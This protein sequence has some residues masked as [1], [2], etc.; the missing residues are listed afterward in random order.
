MK[1]NFPSAQL[2]EMDHVD[3]HSKLVSV[4]NAAASVARFLRF[5]RSLSR[6][7]SLELQRLSMD[8]TELE[9]LLTHYVAMF[10][11]NDVA[12][13]RSYCPQNFV[14]LHLHLFQRFER[15]RYN[16]AR[17][18]VTCNRYQ[19]DPQRNPRPMITV[20]RLI[21]RH[22]RRLEVMQTDLDCL[23]DL[24]QALIRIYG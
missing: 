22:R 9:S 23:K 24:G 10:Q 17:T 19:S 15:F 13:I 3:L 6:K 8:A 2:E 11:F 18:A 20:R 4:A 16:T 21:R 5:L 1:P 12:R 14:S 7:R